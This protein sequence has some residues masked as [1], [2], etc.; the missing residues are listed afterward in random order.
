MNTQQLKELRNSLSFWR[1]DYDRD[2]DKEQYDMFAAAIDA[3]SR[4][5]A[6]QRANAAQD[7]HINQQQTRID[8]L[9]AANSGLGKALGAAKKELARLKAES[10]EPIGEVRLE[11]Y[12]DDGTRPASVVCLHEH[13]GWEN[14]PDGTKLY[15]A[16]QPAALP[17]EMTM[18]DAIKANISTEFMDGANWMREQRLGL[19][20]Q[21][22]P[23][24]ELPDSFAIGENADG[25]FNDVVCLID[26]VKT[27][28]DAAGVKWEVK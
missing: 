3:V 6:A 25:Y 13:A 16:A 10:G 11:D 7:D 27:A 1:D 9:E 19:G 17:T 15:T 4:L 23:V 2:E 24:V 14:F 20:A 26:D 18:S 28:L 5:E 21:P 12:Q 8:W 22:Q